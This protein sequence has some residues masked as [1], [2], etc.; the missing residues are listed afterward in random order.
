MQTRSVF[1]V[2]TGISFL[3]FTVS[4]EGVPADSEIKAIIEW[5]QVWTIRE[6]KS[7]HGL[8]TFYR[9]FI[10]NFSAIMTPIPTG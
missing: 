4:S 8:A 9:Q 10:R 1:S 6:V 7:F 5:S 3:G 2:Q